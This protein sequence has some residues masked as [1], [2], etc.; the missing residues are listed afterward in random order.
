MAGCRTWQRP[1]RQRGFWGFRVQGGLSRIAQ[2][3][4]LRKSQ[5]PRAPGK[6]PS[7]ES[8]L[9]ETLNSWKKFVR[10]KSEKKTMLQDAEKKDKEDGWIAKLAEARPTGRAFKV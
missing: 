7:I 9:P 8:S 5:Q 1:G 10:N 4:W 6:D 3:W 2:R